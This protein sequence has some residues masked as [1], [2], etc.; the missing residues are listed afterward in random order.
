MLSTKKHGKISWFYLLIFNNYNNPFGSG[1]ISEHVFS[2]EIKDTILTKLNDFKPRI[3]IDT[4]KVIQDYQKALD[5]KSE[6]NKALN[7]VHYRLR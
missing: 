2:I 6:Y 1:Y 5:L 3:L 4:D 7:E